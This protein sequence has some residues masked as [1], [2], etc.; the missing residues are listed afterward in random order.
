M[1]NNQKW[2][3]WN[4]QQKFCISIAIAIRFTTANFIWEKGFQKVQFALLT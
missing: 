3:E 2:K 4:L 1:Y